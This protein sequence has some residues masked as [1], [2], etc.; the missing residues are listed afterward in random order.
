MCEFSKRTSKELYPMVFALLDE[1]RWN[2]GALLALV[3]VHVT[4]FLEVFRYIARL[5]YSQPTR[6]DLSSTKTLVDF[7]L[8]L[9]SKY[10]SEDSLFVPDPELID[11]IEFLQRIMQ[12]RFYAFG[13]GHSPRPEDFSRVIEEIRHKSQQ[14]GDTSQ[15]GKQPAGPLFTGPKETEARNS[16]MAVWEEWFRL[17]GDATTNSEKSRLNFIAQI[18]RQGIISSDEVSSLF[19]RTGVE[20]RCSFSLF[21]PPSFFSLLLSIKSPPFYS[22]P[23]WSIS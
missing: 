16:M 22:I 10:V 14:D 19:F 13:S 15:I 21:F 4:S 5:A 9:M 3:R 23:A 17:V 1:G 8:K 7:A 2:V 18:Q 20:K 12:Q 6:G 11:V